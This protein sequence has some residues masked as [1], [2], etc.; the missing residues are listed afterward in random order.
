MVLATSCKILKRL[1]AKISAQKFFTRTLATWRKVSYSA[2]ISFISRLIWWLEIPSSCRDCIVAKNLLMSHLSPVSQ[3]TITHI[4]L[5][6]LSTQ[7]MKLM[8]SS[9]PNKESHSNGE[10]KMR[11]TEHLFLSLAHKERKIPEYCFVP[12]YQQ[13][14][15]NRIDLAEVRRLWTQWPAST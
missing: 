4:F 10:K 1:D 6:R 2:R 7:V 15:N 12:E 3:E 11:R 5:Y 8:C 9:L 14:N 13:S